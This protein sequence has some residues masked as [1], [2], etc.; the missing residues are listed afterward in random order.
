MM[1]ASILAFACA[2][3]CALVDEKWTASL[4]LGKC[5]IAK[6]PCVE[7]RKA[8]CRVEVGYVSNCDDSCFIEWNVRCRIINGL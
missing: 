8:M 3:S 1:E 5:L 2:G 7:S 6:R 4:S